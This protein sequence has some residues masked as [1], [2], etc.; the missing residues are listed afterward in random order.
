MGDKLKSF[1]VIVIKFI[2]ENRALKSI[3]TD[4]KAAIYALAGLRES[5]VMILKIDFLDIKAD[6]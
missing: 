2:S 6:R 1:K 3:L 4:L 5:Q